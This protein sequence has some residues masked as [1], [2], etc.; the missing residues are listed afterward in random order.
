MVLPFGSS[1]F[2]PIIQLRSLST[3]YSD[4]SGFFDTIVTPG[5]YTL[6]TARLPSLFNVIISRAA[7]LLSSALSCPSLIVWKE[8][9]VLACWCTPIPY[10]AISGGLRAKEYY[11]EDGLCV[12]V[13]CHLS[14][15]C[16]SG[17]TILIRWSI[18]FVLIGAWL[19]SV[20]L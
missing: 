14:V 16:L 10:N 9:G 7:S 11:Q 8:F 12:K 5:F 4:A 3:T 15:L 1:H 2:L 6:A 20:S 18:L 17:T 13:I 19:F